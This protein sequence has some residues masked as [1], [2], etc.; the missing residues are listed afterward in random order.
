MNN[1]ESDQLS[2]QK[3]E[4]LTTLLSSLPGMAFRCRFDQDWSMEFVSQGCL[5]LTG[6]APEDLVGNRK[7]SFG[8][9]IHPQDRDLV[10]RQLEIALREKKNF[11]LAYRIY[12]SSG[13]EKW[14]RVRGRGEFGL[15]G[16]VIALEGF[17]SDITDRRESEMRIQR[18]VQRFEALRKIDIAITAS[19]DQRVTLDILL[20]QVTT[21]LEVDA[22]DVLIYNP[23]SR[24]LEFA[25]G[26]GFHTLALQHTRLRLG[27]G[28]AG[29]A[30][31][32]RR[33][34]QV[35]N[36][37]ESLGDLG[38]AADIQDEM[39]YSYFCVPLIAKGQ[40]KGIL[41]VF[42][43]TP[44]KPDAEWLDFLEALA[45]QAAIAVDN[46]TLFNELQRSN[47]E[48]SLA[49]DATLEGWSRALELRD[50]ETE[51]HTKR[52]TELTL[53]LAQ[54][55]HITSVDALHIRRGALLHDIGKMGI[56]DSILRK[57]GPLTGEEWE[58]MRKHPVYAYQWL[59]PITSLR[60]ALDIPYCHHEKWD[61]SGYPR[62]LK[63]EQIPLTARVFAVADVWESL[64]SARVFRPEPWP[65]DKALAYMVEQSG[66][67]F[68]PEVI[69]VFLNMLD[70]TSPPKEG[71]VN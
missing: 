47:L 4:I 59:S 33:S 12:T 32:E 58:I 57:P 37:I 5:D 49:Y 44:L 10:Q 53:R 45:G 56:P 13:V 36:L 60:P 30:A 52:V 18:Q 19:L 20:D 65:K 26:R 40:V 31:L 39:F 42:H 55:M 71:Y 63:G 1:I 38:R 51:G 46:A 24:L 50:Q 54:A 14:V 66:K 28:Y 6:Y 68:D 67:H 11:D 15:K 34:I 9:I 21:H 35:Y 3:Q 7:T 23:G 22:A 62:A 25:A 27:E 17:I 64:N 70:E 69:T 43:R 16:E 48:L 8:Q 61:G 41:E 29:H 2:P